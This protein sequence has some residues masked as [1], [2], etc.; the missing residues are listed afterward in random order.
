MLLKTRPKPSRTGLGEVRQQLN[1][2][3]KMTSSI[4]LQYFLDCYGFGYLP[5]NEWVENS[6]KGGRG[7]VKRLGSIWGMVGGGKSRGMKS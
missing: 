4:V 1:D 2:L 5:G 6:K 3:S 7:L